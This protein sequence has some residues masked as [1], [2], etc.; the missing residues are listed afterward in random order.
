MSQRTVN[1][2]ISKVSTKDWPD[3][4]GQIIK[5]YSF[6][7]EGSFQW[8]R[9]GTNPLPAGTGQSVKFVA[10]GPNVDMATFEVTKSQVAQA[11]SVP[12]TNAGATT[13]A[14][15]SSGA[16]SAPRRAQYTGA[17]S[18]DA[19]A[20]DQYWKDRESRDLEKDERYRAV[21]EPRMAMSVA[22]EAAAPIVVAALQTDGLSL[23]NAS[24]AKKLDLIV[25]Y[26]EQVATRLARFIQSAP[27][28]LKA[29]NAVHTKLENVD[30]RSANNADAS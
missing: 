12:A 6:Q 19:A 25:D 10:D 24:K 28:V 14:T 4:S 26:T 3:R 9:T 5:L 15:A 7:L 23:G 17:R 30:A 11:P 29:E 2:V 22:V 16:P 27:E 18:S 1:G 21:S 8:F 13:T 20:K